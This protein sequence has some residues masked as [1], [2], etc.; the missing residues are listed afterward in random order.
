MKIIFEFDE[1]TGEGDMTVDVFLDEF[2]SIGFL[3]F[4]DDVIELSQSLY[5]ETLERFNNRGSAIAS[6]DLN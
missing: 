1:E 3:D 5:I 6:N 2:G 4:L